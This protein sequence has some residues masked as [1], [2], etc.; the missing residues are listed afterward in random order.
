[1]YTVYTC[2]CLS[3]YSFDWFLACPRGGGSN[4]STRPGLPAIITIIMHIFTNN[5]AEVLYT[6]TLGQCVLQLHDSESPLH[7]HTRTMCAA[8]TWQ[9]MSLTRSHQDNVC[10]SYMTA[11]VP[12]TITPGQCVLQLYDSECRLQG[13]TR[14]M[15][16]VAIW[17]RT[18][19]T[20]SQCAADIWQGMS[21]T[22]SH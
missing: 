3:Q 9:R 10:C 6:V 5:I 14:T 13:H 21:L 11:N 20:R 7:G 17:Q 2:A 19:L 22:R 12:Y 16:V 15:C 1:M 4:H 8:A 18:S